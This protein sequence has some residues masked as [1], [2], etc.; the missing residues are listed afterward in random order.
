[1]N[2]TTGLPAAQ[3]RERSSEAPRDPDAPYPLAAFERRAPAPRAAR[4]S[5]GLVLPWHSSPRHE[6]MHE[7]E[8]PALHASTQGALA[9]WPELLLGEE[10]S[11]YVDPRRQPATRSIL[12]VEDDSRLA[13]AV[14]SAL[15]LDGDATWS[16][17]VAGDGARALE[18][19]MASPPQVILLDVL[20]PRL[21]GVEVYRRLRS[22]PATQQTHVIF[23]SAATSLDLYERGIRDGVLL[24]KPFDLRDLVGLVRGLLAQM[25]TPLD[26]RHP[27][28]ALDNTPGL[29]D[30]TSEHGR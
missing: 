19:A 4:G 23:V 24:R 5:G 10:P 7:P 28:C 17:A 13:R 9:L 26:C 3:E 30:T 16:V 22:A 25:D 20:L 27:G 12:I 1:M 15:E 29:N 21:D 18:L 6:S 14:Q 2:E 11:T 8:H